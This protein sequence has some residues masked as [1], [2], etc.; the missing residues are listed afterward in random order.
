MHIKKGDTVILLAGKDRGKKGKVTHVLPRAERVVIEG[1][2]LF[3]KNVKPR[4]QRQK[5]ER[6]K[7]AA[8]V[9]VAKVQLICPN[10]AK[11]AR[12][13]MRTEGGKKHRVCH[14]CRSVIR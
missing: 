9:H 13:G 12:V 11:P 10:C 14:Q 6:V 1:L 7:Y 5:G 4:Q 3:T 2:N 8:P